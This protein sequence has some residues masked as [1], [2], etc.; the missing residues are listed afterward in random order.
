MARTLPSIRC[1]GLSE[2]RRV[3][4]AYATWKTARK[5]LQEELEKIPLLPSGRFDVRVQGGPVSSP[6]EAAAER[7]FELEGRIMKITGKI[8]DVR[9]F[10]ELLHETDEELEEIFTLKYERRFPDE[11]IAAELGYSRATVERR[12]RAIIERAALFWGM[13]D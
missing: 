1:R 7:R 2:V 6:V 13:Y 11:D 4:R 8:N 12:G 5:K 10:R 9:A 3:L